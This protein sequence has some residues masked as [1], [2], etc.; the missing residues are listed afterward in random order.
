VKVESKIDVFGSSTPIINK[1]PSAPKILKLLSQDTTSI[2]KPAS[3]EKKLTPNA[4]LIA[5][6]APTPSKPVSQ[7]NSGK[8]KASEHLA[9]SSSSTKRAKK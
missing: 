8:R 5:P 1:D 2:V 3:V 4:P 9:A 6:R 7:G